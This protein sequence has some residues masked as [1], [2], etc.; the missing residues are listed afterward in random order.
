MERDR[1][2]LR[3]LR[4]WVTGFLMGVLFTVALALIYPDKFAVRVIER[5]LA[6]QQNQTS[7]LRLKQTN[8]ERTRNARAYFARTTTPVVRDTP[9]LAA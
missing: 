6:P 3:T 2:S 4:S 8:P 1:I 7:P 9:S 5:P